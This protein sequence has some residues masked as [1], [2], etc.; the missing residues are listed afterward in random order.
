MFSATHFT[1][2]GIYSAKYGVLVASFEGE[3]VETTEAFTPTLSTYK[4]VRAQRFYHGG[5]DYG[6]APEY[7]FSIISPEA[8]PDLRRREILSWLVGRGE[9]K[10]L[11]I[12]Q[13]DLE[14]YRYK[15]VFTNAGIITV[16]GQCHGFKLTAK[17][18]SPY[19]Y[20]GVVS[21]TVV[22]DGAGDV[23]IRIVNASDAPEEWTQP[24]VKFRAAEPVDG[25]DIRITNEAD[26]VSG[27]FEFEGLTPNERLVVDNE[28]GKV[29]SDVSGD[30]IACF[31]GN[32]L[33]LKKGANV[34][35][36]RINGEVTIECPQY[37]LIGF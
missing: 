15:C 30:R 5:V 25:K 2:D 4:G 28:L 18:D 10:D 23:R 7:G 6:G 27:A 29:E 8:I 9:F 16:N 34:L 35:T 19:C 14:K 20:G 24:V 31:N 26:T 36:V 22:S 12:H 32:W 17:F 1:Y 3:S 21:G 11:Q 33:R 13:P 37:V